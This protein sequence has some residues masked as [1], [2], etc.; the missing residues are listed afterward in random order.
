MAGAF[1]MTSRRSFKVRLAGAFL[2]LSAGAGLAQD[3]GYGCTGLLTSDTV[4]SV[5]GEGGQFFPVEP[6]LMTLNRMPEEAIADLAQLSAVLEAGGTRLI[7]I[8]TPTKALVMPQALPPLAGFLGYDADLATSVHDEMLREMRAAGIAVVDA[9]QALRR[10]GQAAPVFFG[11]DPR[12]NMA[13]QKA[14][15]DAVAMRIAQTPGFGALAK[16]RYVTLEG[17]MQPLTSL[18]RFKLQQ[19]CQSD[20]PEVA[21]K[22]AVAN[23]APGAPAVDPGAR[24]VVISS[25][26]TGDPALNFAG[27][28]STALGLPAQN[29]WVPGGTSL[30]AISSYVTSRGFERDRPAYLVW[31]NPVFQPLGLFGDQPMAELLAASGAS[32]TIEVPL[33]AQ[34]ASSRLV[35]GLGMLEPGRSY[36]LAF[37]SDSRGA[38]VARFHF[39]AG[40]G[41]IRTRSIHRA[42]EAVPSGR[43]FMP[44]TA[45]G[46]QPAQ[47]EIELDAA[48]G[49]YPRLMA[50]LQEGAL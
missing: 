10:A 9:R 13:G 26:M 45:L 29:V 27:L 30:D 31:E 21:T 43:F 28:L 20:L 25:H 48:P 5:E 17:E 35:A 19:H 4:P 36:T 33:Q 2:A 7:Y 42:V 40:A 8:P 39:D 18:M 15:A 41:M 37:D 38:R 22:V 46:T 47:V 44:M 11:P 1:P 3:S 23:P 12:P 24:V 16:T 6:D 34:P 49:P 50:C 32:C 14:L